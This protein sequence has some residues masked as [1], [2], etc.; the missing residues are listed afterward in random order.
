[1]PF[2]ASVQPGAQL[3]RADAPGS[4]YPIGGEFILVDPTPDGKDRYLEL[5]GHLAW[6]QQVNGFSFSSGFHRLLLETISLSKR[7]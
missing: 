7:L 4:S 3:V 5:V 2:L 6:R 1:M